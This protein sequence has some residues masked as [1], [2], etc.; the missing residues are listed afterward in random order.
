MQLLS[1]CAFRVAA[2]AK[3]SPIRTTF[4]QYSLDMHQNNP[5]IKVFGPEIS[6]FYGVGMGPS[7]A[8]GQLWMEGFLKGV[9]EYEQAHHVIL[10]DG[11]SF[12]RYPFNNASEVPSLLM[13]S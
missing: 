6:Q 8:D 2:G 12:H 7:D 5:T 3:I 4:I 9:G 1:F 11:V 13:S 10:L